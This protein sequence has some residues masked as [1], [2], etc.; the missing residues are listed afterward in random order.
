M[1]NFKKEFITPARAQEYLQANINNRMVRRPVVSRYA[2][3]IVNGRWKED[4]AEA[5]KIAKSGLVLDG[6]HRLHAIVKAGLGVWVHVA[7]GLEET[8]FDVLDTNSPRNASDTFKVKGIKSETS[9]PSIIQFAE[10]LKKGKN[11]GDKAMR[12]TNALLLEQYYADANFWDEVSRQTRSWYL[13]FARILQPSIIGGL[14]AFLSKMDNEKAYDFCNQLATGQDIS[15]S[16]IALLRTKLMQD[17]MNSKKMPQTLK[18][19][20]ILKTWN[21]YITGKTVEFLRFE[22][23]NDIYP[24]AINPKKYKK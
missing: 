2:N 4:T 8:V 16:T 1:I 9:L 15:N 19:A 14:Y 18:I 17:K 3:D 10:L 12:G 22:P 20:F 7:T 23:I 21:Y 11:S 13:S 5:I 24:V 6:Q